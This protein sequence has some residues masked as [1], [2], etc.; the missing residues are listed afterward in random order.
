MRIHSAFYRTKDGSCDYQF[1]FEEQTDG[2]WRPYILSQ[3]NYN[4]RETDQHSTHR[5][6]DDSRKYICW[7]RPLETLDEAK[8]V[9]AIWAEKT[10]EYIRSGTRF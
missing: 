2:I 8:Q 5:L 7:D 1:S 4:G 3:P 6:A 10:Q 9:A